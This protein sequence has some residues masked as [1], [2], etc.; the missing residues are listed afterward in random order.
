MSN[1]L[2]EAAAAVVRARDRFSGAQYNSPGRVALLDA[3][4]RLREVLL[5]DLRASPLESVCVA[6]GM[7]AVFSHP[8]PVCSAHLTEAV[9]QTI[10]AII[11]RHRGVKP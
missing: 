11:A 2:M 9:Q 10:E 8:V 3:I 6:C 7:P 1:A 4:E 5:T